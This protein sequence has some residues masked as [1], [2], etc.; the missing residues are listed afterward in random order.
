MAEDMAKRIFAPLRDDARSAARALA[1]LSPLPTPDGPVTVVLEADGEHVEVEI[2]PGVYAVLH[3]ILWTLAQG[4]AIVL[5]S[6]SRRPTI[7]EAARFVGTGRT[8]LRRMLR[9]SDRAGPAR[10]HPAAI[11][12]ILRARVAGRR[13]IL[14]RLVCE[15]QETGIAHPGA[16]GHNFR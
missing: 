7:G 11:V 1:S 9:P 14:D 12:R 16:G 15:A 8:V 5:R 3:G 4:R 2:T 6:L 10:L 13:R